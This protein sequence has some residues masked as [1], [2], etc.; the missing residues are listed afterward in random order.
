MNDEIT[1]YK[2]IVEPST[3]NI[4]DAILLANTKSEQN[5]MI[6]N[7]RKTVILNVAFT[8]KPAIHLGITYRDE[9]L[10][11]SPSEHTKF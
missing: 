6:L 10:F 3:E 2:P 9:S 4:S 8:K 11:I 5:N 1:F 7:S